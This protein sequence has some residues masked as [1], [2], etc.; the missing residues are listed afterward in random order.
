M[1]ER[2][3]AQLPSVKTVSPDWVVESVKANKCLDWEK[4]DVDLLVKPIPPKPIVAKP[5]IA[6]SPITD[7]KPLAAVLPGQPVGAL[8]SSVVSN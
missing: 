4:Y 3:K 5:L 8:G 6:P 1:Y 7:Q 2:C